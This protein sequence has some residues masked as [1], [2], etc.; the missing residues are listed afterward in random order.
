MKLWI[1]LIKNEKITKSILYDVKVFDVKKLLDYLTDICYT[2]D[3]PRPIV[4]EK[5]YRDFLKFNHT[6]FK[7]DDFVENVDFDKLW[8]EI[9]IS[10]NKKST[11]FYSNL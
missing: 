7:K 3:I 6:F 1:K 10:K 4:I 5:H 8:I 11:D 9:A 2:L